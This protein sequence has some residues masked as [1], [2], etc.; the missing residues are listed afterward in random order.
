MERNI[1]RARSRRLKHRTRCIQSAISTI[2]PN[3]FSDQEVGDLW[4]GS[5]TEAKRACRRAQRR[6]LFTFRRPVE[7][8]LAMGSDPS[9][10]LP[11]PAR[12]LSRLNRSAVFPALVPA[13]TAIQQ[14]SLNRILEILRCGMPVTPLHR[15]LDALATASG[16]SW[17]DSAAILLLSGLIPIAIEPEVIAATRAARDFWKQYS[18]G[19]ERFRNLVANGAMAD[20]AGKWSIFE[21]DQLEALLPGIIVPTRLRR[22][23]YLVNPV[24]KNGELSLDVHAGLDAQ[25]LF[26][27][28]FPNAFN[29]LHF[30]R[31]P[32]KSLPVEMLR[33]L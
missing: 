17:E 10:V 24:W 11:R 27:H 13:A 5:L 18:S 23:D 31:P 1:R 26:Q 3:I 30:G 16:F 14:P 2:D 7:C 19:E 12:I 9:L 28:P 25:P 8:H 32:T 6:Q 22:H 29:P 15:L 21:H 4:L 33:N 20:L